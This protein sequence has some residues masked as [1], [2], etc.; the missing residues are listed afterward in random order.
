[1]KFINLTP[2]PVVLSNGALKV[3]FAKGY[4]VPIARV[5]HFTEE[6]ALTCEV[7]PGMK[8]DMPVVVVTRSEVQGLPEPVKDTIYIVSGM[9]ATFVKR[10]DVV[11]PITD[12][13]CERD[14]QGRVISV[15]GFQAYI[16]TSVDQQVLEEVAVTT[17]A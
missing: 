6:R 3:T 10:A 16:P 5:E 13:T 8:V 12:S 1:M 7:A 17:E 9:V 2:H 11:S 15:K 4:G 14:S